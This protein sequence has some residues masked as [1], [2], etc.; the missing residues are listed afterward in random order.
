MGEKRNEIRD[1][2]FER[3]AGFGNFTKRE[4]STYGIEIR[5]VR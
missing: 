1:C 4:M 2:R 5:E 3:D